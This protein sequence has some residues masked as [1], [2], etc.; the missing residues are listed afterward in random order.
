MLLLQVEAAREQ[1]H[2]LQVENTEH[3][4]KER[5]LKGQL[6]YN[7]NKQIEATTAL[8]NLENET[9]GTQ[10][11]HL[12]KLK[13]AWELLFNLQSVLAFSPCRAARPKLRVRVETLARAKQAN[14]CMRMGSDTSAPQAIQRA[15]TT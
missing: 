4:R 7:K 11:S 1:H 15:Q 10:T 5:C 12:D 14:G 13:G 8:T 6:V 3:K 9:V 2:L